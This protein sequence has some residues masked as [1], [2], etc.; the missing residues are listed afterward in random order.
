MNH[1][2]RGKKFD[3]ICLSA[4]NFL[5]CFVKGSSFLDR[6]KSGNSEIFSCSHY[7]VCPFFKTNFLVIFLSC[8]MARLG[9]NLSILV[10]EQIFFRESSL[11]FDFCPTEYLSFSPNEA[12]FC[13]NFAFVFHQRS[14][15]E[16]I[17]CLGGFPVP[18]AH[19]I[20]EL[21]LHWLACLPSLDN[22]FL[23]DNPAFLGCSTLS[24][25]SSLG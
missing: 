17:L 5:C 8:I 21:L 4:I 3:P 9:H 14:F 1:T 13:N 18:N 12:C 25:N 23:P 11:C 16:A 7:G 19:F 6:V 20:S 2:K 10:L 24:R 22:T 15:R